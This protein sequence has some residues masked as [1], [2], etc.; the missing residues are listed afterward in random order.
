[1]RPSQIGF[2]KRKYSEP[3]KGGGEREVGFRNLLITEQKRKLREQQKA[4]ECSMKDAKKIL[5]L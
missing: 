5:F 4:K 3:M 1:M 2:L